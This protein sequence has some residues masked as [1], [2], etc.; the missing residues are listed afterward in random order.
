MRLMPILA[1]AMAALAAPAQ[2]Q[3]APR[4]DARL[5]QAIVAGCAAHASAKDAEPCDR[6]R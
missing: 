5:A 6:R 2:A 1:A 4:L 3:T